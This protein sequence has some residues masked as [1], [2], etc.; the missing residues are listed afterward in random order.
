MVVIILVVMLVT[1]Q[2]QQISEPLEGGMASCRM[3]GEQHLAEY[4]MDPQ[5]L[6]A[7][8]ACMNVPV[9]T[10]GPEATRESWLKYR[11]GSSYS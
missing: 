6:K 1:G 11:G 7:G 4:A 2:I 10:L 5:V 3:H 8:Y 9:H